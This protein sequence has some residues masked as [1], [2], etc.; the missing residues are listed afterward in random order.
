MKNRAFLVGVAVGT[1]ALSTSLASAGGFALREQSATSQGASFA[2]AAT[3]GQG[4]SAMFWN[5]SAVTNTDGLTSEAH[6]AFILPSA[7]LENINRVPGTAGLP[8]PGDLGIDAWIPGSYAAYRVND[9]IYLGVSVNAPFGLATRANNPS[10]AQVDN[11]A[12][13]VFSTTVTPTIG[14]KVNDQLSVGLGLEIQ[15]LKVDLARATGPAAGAVAAR[16]RG[17]DIGFGF[18]AGLTYKPFEGTEVGL[19]FRSAVS[20]DLEGTL[21]AAASNAIDASVTMPES[22]S[23]GIRQR[24]NDQF[25]LL[26]TVEWTNWSRLGTIPV[27]LK[28]GGATATTLPFEYEDGWYFALGGEYA[29][30]DALTVRAGLG[31]EISPV[32]DSHRSA[33]LPDSNRV[34]A[35]VGLSYAFNEH[36]SVDGAYTHIF[37]EAAPIGLSTGILYS[38]TTKA[39]VDIF[40]LAL[41]YKM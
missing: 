7:K 28:A 31:Y 39:S 17:D 38:A 37:A 1:L 5:P 29:W 24:V 40:A 34:W 25:T 36:L 13:K 12:S 20:H 30:N 16:I 18:T 3:P 10:I 27:T 32:Q 23:L 21:T 4:I 9:S 14:Y 11:L 19:G 41:R 22:V 6:N 2:G 35:S 26:G 33:R 15:Y 8:E